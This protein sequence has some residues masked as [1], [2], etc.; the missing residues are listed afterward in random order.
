MTKQY[1]LS[2]NDI[3]EGERFFLESIANETNSKM[4]LL[5]KQR[6]MYT[7][8]VKSLYLFYYFLS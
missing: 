2:L 3:R 6:G 7:Q 4:Q 8:N 1:E 5:P